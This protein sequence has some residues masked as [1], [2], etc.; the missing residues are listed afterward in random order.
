MF[1]EIETLMPQ[2]PQSE[3][4]MSGRAEGEG[5]LAQLIKWIEPENTGII[6]GP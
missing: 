1:L 4:L 2:A 5:T 6:A 3:A